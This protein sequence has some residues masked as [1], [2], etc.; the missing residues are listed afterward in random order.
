MNISTEYEGIPLPLVID[1]K[2][3]D[4]NLKKLN[5]TKEWLNSELQKF[6]IPSY[7]DAFFV[8]LQTNGSL[9]FQKKSRK[10]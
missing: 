4:L 8:S 1:G 5:L 10:P 7:K 9:F 2:L 3:I 6:D